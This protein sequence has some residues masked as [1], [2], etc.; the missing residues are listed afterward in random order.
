MMLP[1]ADKASIH[2]HKILRYLLDPTNPN[3]RGKPAFYGRLGYTRETW[4]RLHDD[5]LMHARLYP[6]RQIVEDSKRE[7]VTYVIEGELIGPNGKRRQ[8]RSVWRREPTS[9]GPRFVT[10][11]PL[12]PSK[13]KLIKE[14]AVKE[15]DTIEVTDD[16]L[17]WSPPLLRGTTGVIVDLPE[18]SD[19]AVVEVDY[20]EADPAVY[21]L[22][23]DEMRVI[24]HHAVTMTPGDA[25]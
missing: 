18:S 7:A 11:Y 16:H 3:S 6:V 4:G 23:R 17:D 8:L 22:H 19:I 13:P 14:T 15:Y 20:P 10:A 1:D 25:H 21:M 24:E 2:P 12:A 5:L 9:L